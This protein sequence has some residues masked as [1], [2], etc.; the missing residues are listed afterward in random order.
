LVAFA[1]GLPAS[2]AGS[3]FVGIFGCLFALSV[4]PFQP[5]LVKCAKHT[6]RYPLAGP[7]ADHPPRSPSTPSPA[8]YHQ[9]AILPARSPVGRLHLRRAR[10]RRNNHLLT[11]NSKVGGWNISILIDYRRQ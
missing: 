9:A 7:V 3:V 2:L 4:N 1:S 5:S 8:A 10:S 6:G 11:H